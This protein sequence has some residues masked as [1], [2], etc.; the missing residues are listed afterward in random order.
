VRT[1][2]E[3]INQRDEIVMSMTAMNLI[4]CRAEVSPSDRG[5]SR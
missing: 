1:S 4:R 5:N 3:A 2:I